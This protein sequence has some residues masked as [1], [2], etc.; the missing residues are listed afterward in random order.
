MKPPRCSATLTEVF[1]LSHC[2]LC[3]T[4]RNCGHFY[5]EYREP[6]VTANDA[7]YIDAPRVGAL[8]QTENSLVNILETD[9]E[10]IPM[11]HTQMTRVTYLFGRRLMRGLNGGWSLV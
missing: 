5:N 10:R 3:V 4:K 1:I 7:E 11:K 9:V 8:Q 6:G 2:Q